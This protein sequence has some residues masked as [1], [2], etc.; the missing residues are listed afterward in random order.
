MN[1]DVVID[2]DAFADLR[3]HLFRADQDEHAAI[4]LAGMHEA[5]SRTRLLVRELHLVPPES[6]TPGRYGYR[7]IAPRYIAEMASRAGDEELSFVSFHSHPGA[8]RSVSLSGDDRAAHARLF[9]HLLD[10]TG[11]RPVA[12]VAMGSESADGEVWMPGRDSVSLNAVRVVGASLREFRSRPS[13][14]ELDYAPRY[15]RQARMF[16]SAGQ[17]VLSRM[18]VAVIGAGGGGSMLVEQI[19]HLGV[20]AITVVDYD[21]VKAVNLSRIVG[22]TTA[23]VGRKKVDVLGRLVRSVN[24]ECEYR[25]IG[26]NIADLPVAAAVLESDFIFLATDT[27]TSRLVFNAIVHRYLIPGIQIG[28]K[29]EVRANGEIDQIY[30]AIR[31]V[32]PRHGCLQCNSLIDPMRLQAESRT[33]EEQRAQNYI[34]EPEV[35]DPAVVSLNGIA[36]SH[37]VN[38]MLFAATG[39]AD[40]ALLHHKLIFPSS[41]ELMSV[42]P[43]TDSSCAFCGSHR[44]SHYARGGPAELLPVRRPSDRSTSPDGVFDWRRIGT[45][46][47]ARLNRFLRRRTN[48]STPL[49]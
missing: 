29:V 9:P 47:F 49:A 3:R 11:G 22:S 24:P 8:C 19:A 6:F 15:D 10:L 40:P 25:A 30:V 46:R 1:V 32:F 12:G 44:A 31:P 23:D 17:E 13:H 35:I 16:G 28:A 33:D 20:G 21:T 37:A 18:K 26:G 36:A 48:R 5:G 27:I 42:Q 7:Q 39:L 43:R 41:G 38:T 14:A 45:S 2:D 34:N 4:A